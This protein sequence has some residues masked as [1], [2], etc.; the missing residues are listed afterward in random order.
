MMVNGHKNMRI[1][2][3][4]MI[5]PFYTR[6]SRIRKCGRMVFGLSY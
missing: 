2:E 3:K 4:L 6:W 1:E 5:R